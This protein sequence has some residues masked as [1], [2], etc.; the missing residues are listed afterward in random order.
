M[1]VFISHFIHT[2]MLENVIT[3]K[4]INCKRIEKQTE[5]KTNKKITKR[6]FVWNLKIV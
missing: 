6:L 3:D 5:T 1:R 4:T 2:S